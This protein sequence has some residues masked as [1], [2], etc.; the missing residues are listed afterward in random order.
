[1]SDQDDI[2][3]IQ[4]AIRDITSPLLQVAKVKAVVRGRTLDDLEAALQ[5]LPPT[6]TVAGA[7]DEIRQRLA[8]LVGRM[9]QARASAFGQIENT[10]IKQARQAKRSVK[11]LNE[12]WRVGPLEIQMRRERGQVRIQYNREEVLGWMPVENPEELE[13]QFK[14][15]ESKLAGLELPSEVRAEVFW[16]AYEFLR[17][18]NEAKGA[19]S[20]GRIPILDFYRRV[21]VELVGHELQGRAPDRKL[22]YT[23]MPRWAFVYN[24]DRY[25]DQGADGDH[26]VALETGSSDQQSKGLGLTTNGLE[27]TNDYKTFCYVVAVAPRSKA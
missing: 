1:M 24:L 20:P 27:A 21:R 16:K 8:T 22:T 14:K 7:V 12:A 23:E 4:K 19:T 10:F 6:A 5:R 13:D 9:K 18:E 25:R 2:K 17:R 3:A 26:R 11:E 15:A